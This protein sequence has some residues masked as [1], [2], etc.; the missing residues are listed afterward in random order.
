MRKFLLILGI[1]I[2]TS[3]ATFAAKIPDEVQTY[4]KNE[5]PNVDIRFDGVIIMPSNTIYLP[6]YPAL[7]ADKKSL[8]IKETYPAGLSLRQ[9]PNIVIFNNDFVLM[10]VLTDGEG[11][12][13]VMHQATPPLEVR[14]GLLPQDMLVPS[15]LI[16]PENIKSIIGNLKIDTKSEDII[17]VNN[18]DTFED[19]IKNAGS[20]RPQ[21]LISQL[22]NKIV[23]VT[24]NYSK[25]IQVVE[26]GHGVP[27]YSLA[28]KSIPIDVKAVR[29]GKF[30]LV[31]SYDR[32]F[33]DVVSV[34]D[35]RFI[36]QISL[37]SNPEQILLDE[38]NEKAYITSPS[39]STIFVVDLK[40]MCLVQKIKINGYCEHIFLGSDKLF[41]VDKL[42]NEI[43]AIELKK[44]YELKDIGK[45][46]NVSALAYA[47]NKLFISSRTK[48]RIAVIDY[49]TL[50]LVNEY[51]TVSKPTAM[52]LQGDNLYVLGSQ[53]NEIQIIDTKN[54]GIAGKIELKTGGFSSG[55][56]R[57]YGTN[58]AIVTDIKNNYYTIIDLNNGTVL[59]TYEL[60]IPIKDVI[61]ADKVRLFD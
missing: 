15:G 2:L 37:G 30:L 55:L 54:S 52:I 41:Y 51:T 10:R 19:F 47:N 13:T 20:D 25:N 45:F 46:P 4:I 1:F 24:T 58:Y 27:K 12:R 14:T 28:Q 17:K 49:D 34:A 57:I 43:W 53:G 48:S 23:F 60:S 38:N 6:L 18:E 16:I 9:E 21:P 39:A 50:G 11:H 56:T 22:A 7:F 31:T 29:E 3:S 33:I 42:N 26:P 8:A 61:I 5:V 35:S 44:D 32:P 36:K 40:T 59:K